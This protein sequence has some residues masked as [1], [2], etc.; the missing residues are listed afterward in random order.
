MVHPDP[1]VVFHRERLHTIGNAVISIDATTKTETLYFYS[2][3]C[4]HCC[5]DDDDDSDGCDADDDND[6]YYL[7]LLPDGIK[8]I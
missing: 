7:C 2:K 1:A 5:Y 3:V 6:C 4:R 8:C